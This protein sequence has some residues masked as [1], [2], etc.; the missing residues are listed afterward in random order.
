M[1]IRT[2]ALLTAEEPEYGRLAARLLA[3]VI[4]KEVA[5]IEI[6]AF[7]QSVQRGHERAQ[8]VRRER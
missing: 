5:G 8:H 7:S 2:A 4:E 6:H 3:G 1:S